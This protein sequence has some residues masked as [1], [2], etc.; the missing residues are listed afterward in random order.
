MSSAP[1]PASVILARREADESVHDDSKTYL[2]ATIPSTPRITRLSFTL[3]SN[4]QG[5]SS[6]LE[7]NGTY[8]GSWPWLD[9]ELWRPL[10]SSST[11]PPPNFSLAGDS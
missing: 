1:N 3:R 7:D 11:P 4:D 5:W 10:P 8:K 2:T 9:V 6:S